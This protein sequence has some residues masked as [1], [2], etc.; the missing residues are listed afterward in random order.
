MTHPMEQG[1]NGA[2]RGAQGWSPINNQRSRGFTKRTRRFTQAS[3]G[4]REPMVERLINNQRVQRAHLRVQR[5]HSRENDVRDPL[6]SIR[7]R[8]HIENHIN[9]FGTHIQESQSK[10]SKTQTITC[11]ESQRAPGA[12][13]REQISQQTSNRSL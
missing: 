11:F 2:Q 7:S 12:H 10:Q 9:I 13:F 6:S 4:I 1:N 5:T 8:N 3:Q